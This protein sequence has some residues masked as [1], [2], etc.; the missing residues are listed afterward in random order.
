MR[1]DFRRSRVDW[2]IEI[3]T[4]SVLALSVGVVVERTCVSVVD[5]GVSLAVTI[6]IAVILQCWPSKPGW[7][8]YW[9]LRSPGIFL[10]KLTAKWLLGKMEMGSTTMVISN[11]R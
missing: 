1:I 7:G 8:R 10:M 11:S 3:T 6:F 2:D 4:F 9:G 5:L